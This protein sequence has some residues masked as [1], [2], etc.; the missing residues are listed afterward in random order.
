MAT[1]VQLLRGGTFEDI[2]FTDFSIE[3]GISTQKTVP[4]ASFTTLATEAVSAGQEARIVIDGVT[5]FKGI[6][7][8]SGRKEQGQ[9]TVE[10][11]HDASELFSSEATFTQTGPPT[12]EDVLFAAVSNAQTNQSFTLDYNATAVLLE[13]EYVAEGRAVK[14]IFQDMMDRTDYIWWTDPVDNIVHVDEKGGRG[15]WQSL[16]TE[17]DP[18]VEVRRFDE[19]NI[20]TVRNAV[21]VIGTRGLAQ[22]ATRTDSNSIS[23]YG[24]RSK[25]YQVD[26][27]I[28]QAA[29]D[30]LALA[31]LQPNPIPEGEV[32]VSQNVGAVDAPRVNQTID[33]DDSA[34]DISANSLLVERQTIEQGRATLSAGGGA[35]ATVED[36]N[37]TAKSEGDLT[38]PGSVYD[39]DRIADGAITN[40]EIGDRAVDSQ[41]IELSAIIAENLA[42]SAVER[43]KI[44]Q[45]AINGDKVETGTI[46]ATKL[47]IEDWI[48]IGLEFREGDAGEDDFDGNPLASDE[49]AWNDH[50]IVFEGTEY[51]ILNNETNDKYVYYT[52]GDF[53]Y[54]TSN[55]KP[56]IGDDQAL[57][58]I[59]DPLGTANQILQA[60]S[61]HGGSI[62]TRSIEAAE[63]ATGT[64]TADLVDTFDLGTQQ[65]TVGTQT[66]D[67][68]IEFVVETST[69]FGDIAVMKPTGDGGQLGNSTDRWEDIFTLDL[70]VDQRVVTNSFEAEVSSGDT[71]VFLENVS[72]VTQLRPGTDNAGEVGTG[73]TAWSEMNAHNFITQSPDPDVPS[74]DLSQLLD[75][76]WYNP[77]EYATRRKANGQSKK[78]YRR[79]N[80][81]SDGVELSHMANW[82]LETCKAQ[83]ERIDSLEERL[84]RLESQ[85]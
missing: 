21:T 72:G 24:R 78:S 33:L 46:G 34:Q 2:P 57:V 9:Q 48:P 27:A 79:A 11:T 17:A 52:A 35:G 20:A 70:D 68:G 26:Y 67:V 32:A 36:V 62:R 13:N 51:D 7:G 75:M 76:D 39:S 8:N 47:F 43:A 22:S 58:A 6:C 12:D 40:A 4:E 64:L 38:R 19:G 61:I 74:P 30:K 42:A 65:L 56:D 60:T 10:L 44:A 59:N 73:P 63:I 14:Q 71:D 82:L 31:L 1:D 25:A 15:L 18:G 45:A 80:P 41:Q 37:R 50:S 77:P 55:T 81:S 85:V 5:R 84:S 49:I 54:T 28:T 16:D 23:Q 69:T 53:G 3:L 83:Q 29:A 66:N